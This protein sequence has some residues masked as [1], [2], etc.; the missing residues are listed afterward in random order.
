[1]SLEL[2]NK[3]GLFKESPIRKIADMLEAARKDPQIISFGGGEPSLDPPLEMLDFLHDELRLDPHRV[4][5]YTTTSGLLQL[6][7]EIADDLKREGV[8]VSQENIVLTIG[9]AEGIYLACRA[10]INAGDEVLL[11]NPTYV[12]Y[13]PCVV[14]NSGKVRWLPVR[15]Q[16]NFQ[17][18]LET[19]KEAISRKTKAIILLSPDNP[20]GRIL[21]K[22]F[23][24]GISDL[25]TDKDFFIISDEAYKEMIYEGKHY[26][27]S[28]YT[29]NAIVACSFS[30]VA[31]MPGF[32]EGYVYCQR[33]DVVKGIVK[34]K[35]FVSLCSV[36]PAQIMLTRFYQ[37]KIKD[38]YLKE[39]VIPTYK[40]RR[41]VMVEALKKN[42]PMAQFAKP[43]GAFYIFPDMLKYLEN[44][45]CDG[46]LLDDEKFANELFKK[47]KVV[48]VPGHYFGP[49]G[50]GHVRF[51]FVTEPEERIKEGIERIA[52][53]VGAEKFEAAQP[54]D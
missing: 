3:L 19:V 36:L 45:G 44:V 53:F 33:R 13:E 9:A 25:A 42:L 34:I 20:T 30:K 49:Y 51:T 31:S 15:W 32:R 46:K 23:V 11:F 52:R 47:E 4:C 8:D 27:P 16:E 39:I 10:L 14:L 41:D 2:S 12:Q 7:I 22:D 37:Q 38:K 35:Q 50:R 29:E 21:T 17:P 5:T 40:K 6:R 18:D 54:V 26:S 48:V 43:S 28:L 1:M 24:K